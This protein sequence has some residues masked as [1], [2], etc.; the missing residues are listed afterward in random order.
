MPPSKGKPMLDTLEKLNSATKYPSIPTYHSMDKG[1]LGDVQVD[2]EGNPPIATE[3][4]DGVNGRI[5][6][7]PKGTWF[8]GSRGELLTAEDDLVYNR[9]GGIVD[10]LRPL[11]DALRVA[12]DPSTRDRIFVGYFEVY[13]GKTTKAAK[14]YTGSAA[15]GARLFDVCWLEESVLDRD[16]P[17]IAKWRDDGGQSYLEEADLEKV[18]YNADVGLTPRLTAEPPPIGI[19]ETSEWLLATIPKSRATLDEAAGAGAEG[20]VLRTDDRTRIAKVRFEDYQRHMRK[21]SGGA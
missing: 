14:Q 5:I 18:A 4:I 8:I 15:L 11:A 3:K 2:F 20:L 19:A 21:F 6:V 16:R 13:G 17:S 1:R 12:L 10:T 9:A 7:S